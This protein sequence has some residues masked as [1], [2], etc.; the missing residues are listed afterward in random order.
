M[1][2]VDMLPFGCGKSKKSRSPQGDNER[3][4]KI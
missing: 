4:E 3:R 1:K 2:A